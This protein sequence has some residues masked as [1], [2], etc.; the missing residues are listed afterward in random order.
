MGRQNFLH[1]LAAWQVDHPSLSGQYHH[2]QTQQFR[3][4]RI[5]MSLLSLRVPSNTKRKY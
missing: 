3:H 2:N 1:P 4:P 5:N